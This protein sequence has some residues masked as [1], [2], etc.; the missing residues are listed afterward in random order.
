M[1]DIY[2]HKQ[3]KNLRKFN[4]GNYLGFVWNVGIKLVNLQRIKNTNKTLTLC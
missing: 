1:G 3:A 4:G 2:S